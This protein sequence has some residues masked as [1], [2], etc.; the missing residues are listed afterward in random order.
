MCLVM[1]DKILNVVDEYLLSNT[2]FFI[3]CFVEG[4]QNGNFHLSFRAKLEE[5]KNNFRKMTASWC[6]FYTDID[7]SVS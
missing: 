7:T 6:N 5:V 4:G 2:L 1:K 3:I